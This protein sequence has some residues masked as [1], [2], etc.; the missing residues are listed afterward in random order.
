MGLSHCRL[1]GA[2]FRTRVIDHAVH[3]LLVTGIQMLGPVLLG[4]GLSVEKATM[5]QLGVGTVVGLRMLYQLVKS[6]FTG[7][8]GRKGRVFFL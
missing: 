4:F 2:P 3:N 6:F 8:C 1:W 7:N 5:I